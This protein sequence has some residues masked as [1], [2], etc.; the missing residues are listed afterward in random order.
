MNFAAIDVETANA[1]MASICQIGIASFR[2]GELV[3][4]W[5]S[6][7]NPED[8]FD[9]P[10]ICVHGIRPEDVEGAPL[11]PNVIEAVA[12]R[13]AGGVA[14]CHTHFDRVAVHQACRKYELE[15][16]DCTWLD[17]A[18]VARRTWSEFA[19][20]GYGLQNVCDH[21]GYDYA[22]HDALEDAK[23]A[24][25]VL[26]AAARKTGLSV[27][28]WLL[29]VEKPINP[30]ASGSKHVSRAGNPDGALFGEVIVFT[31]KLTILRDD[32]ADLADALGC[33]VSDSLT[34]KTTM[35]VVGDQDVA[36]L[37]GH[38]KSSKHRKAEALIAQGRALRILRESDFLEMVALESASE[39]S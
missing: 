6:L 20:F 30:S 14:V 18:R 25:H 10:N 32:A 5:K 36:K 39:C 31:G 24:G 26:L 23:A 7:I 8:F 2:Q 33:A 9:Y 12:S 4:E 22:A 16:P 34:L 15:T 27:E 35:L 1:N 37:A 11:L 3:D 38:D 21:I 13:L 29:R 19:S 17:S 28:D